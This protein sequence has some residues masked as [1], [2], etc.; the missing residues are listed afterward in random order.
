MALKNKRRGREGSSVN[1]DLSGV[2][3]SRRTIPEGTY[4]LVV[5]QVEQKTSREGNPMISFE[6]EVSEG[7]HKGA[8]LFE[9]CSLQP[10]A[11]F[12]LKSVLLAL[13][14]EI[15]N[16]AFDLNLKDLI[17]L[18][19][20]VEVGHETYEGKK[21]ARILEYINPEEKSEGSGEDEDEEEEEESEDL[22]DTLSE[23]D[24][25]ELKD[26]ALELDIPKKKVL[27]AK[28][29]KDL[30]ALILDEADE[31][32]IREALGE[33]SSDE[34]ESEE[35]EDDEV[36]YSEMSLSELK[37][38]CK[39]RGLKVKKGMDKDDLIELLEEDDEEG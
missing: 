19:C 37:A 13:G 31:D 12:K 35:D 17:G 32:D 24:K 3:T 39:D 36:D 1:V 23:M 22:E 30:V 21:R 15:P 38:E 6:F 28:K 14:M 8:K 29:V 16:K 9:N 7:P 34:E 2:E 5:N 26:L 20:E 4:S 18:E 33:G 11:L 27:A 10:Q 25:D